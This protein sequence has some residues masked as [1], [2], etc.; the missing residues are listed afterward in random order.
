[1]ALFDPA[2]V[3]DLLEATV[4]AFSVLGGVMAYWSGFSAAQALA[5]E[6]P[7]EVLAHL[8]NEGIARGFLSGSPAAVAALIIMVWT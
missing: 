2:A 6:A 8:I 7:P 4:A 5:L 3:R 1:M